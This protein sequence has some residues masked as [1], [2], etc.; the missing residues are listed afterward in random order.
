MPD[1]GMKSHSFEKLHRPEQV[2]RSVPKP[3]QKKLNQR[4]EKVRK[5]VPKPFQIASKSIANLRKSSE[6]ST[7]HH[8]HM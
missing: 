8:R 4:P 7:S 6:C 3:T 1:L 5:R 2:R